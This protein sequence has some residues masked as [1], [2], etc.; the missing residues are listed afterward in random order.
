MPQG[1]SPSGNDDHVHAQ[2]ESQGWSAALE[3]QLCYEVK[4]FLL[5][6]HE[7]SAAM[8]TWTFYELTQHP[9][10]L[11]RVGCPCVAASPQ[12]PDKAYCISFYQDGSRNTVA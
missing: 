5:A 6:G 2:A 11:A 3:T 1:D 9:D 10:V 8:L 4:T 7:T 12:L